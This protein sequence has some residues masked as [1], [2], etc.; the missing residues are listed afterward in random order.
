MASNLYEIL[1]LDRNASPED[2]RS[3]FL[4]VGL[5]RFIDFECIGVQ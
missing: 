2:G 4:L 5:W 1:E 3:C